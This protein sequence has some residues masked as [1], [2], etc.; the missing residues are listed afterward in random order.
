MKLYLIISF[1]LTITLYFTLQVLAM[2]FG[3]D[4]TVPI[5]GVIASAAIML[6]FIIASIALIY[7]AIKL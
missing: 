2:L 7:K 5:W 6:N 4:T 1:A 3:G